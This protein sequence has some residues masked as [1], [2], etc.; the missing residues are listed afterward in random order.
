MRDELAALGRA[1][2]D[3]WEVWLAARVDGAQSPALHP[4]A[5][6]LAELERLEAAVDETVAAGDELIRMAAW[7][8]AGFA[9]GSPPAP[10]TARA[11]TAERAA[12]EAATA[13]ASTIARGTGGI[14]AH[15]HESTEGVGRATERNLSATSAARPPARGDAVR[16]QVDHRPRPDD[17]RQSDAG[18]VEARA[19]EEWPDA[20]PSKGPRPSSL[21]TPSGPA[22]GGLGDLAA[23]ASAWGGEVLDVDAEPTAPPA[24]PSA[25]A[26]DVRSAPSAGVESTAAALSDSARSDH[27][28]R[29]RA[30]L[31][32]RLTAPIQ[33]GER[34]EAER[35]GLAPSN[36]SSSAPSA[37]S[38]TAPRRALPFTQAAGEAASTLPGAGEDGFVEDEATR[39]EA[40]VS[41]GSA[42]PRFAGGRVSDGTAPHPRAVTG[43][44][45]TV[46]SGASAPLRTTDDP[47]AR[48]AEDRTSVPSEETRDRRPPSHSV[49]VET[50][51]ETESPVVQLD[52]AATELVVADVLDALSREIMFEYRRH[53]GS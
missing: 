23:L 25:P 48:R 14:D 35:G 37:C 51:T 41:P 53:Y 7:L 17:F 40:P 49:T 52:P 36:G 9:A 38:P 22:V 16:T 34:P 47:T 2:K 32:V 42:S 26:T 39:P 29:P 21:P 8:T 15:R 3:E 13:F 20:A 44:G 10:S 46:G 19:R 50:E 6:E 12:R 45:S 27:A 28:T 33:R 5:A 18:R 24:P 43:A 4:A 31:P 1:L 30:T 11:P